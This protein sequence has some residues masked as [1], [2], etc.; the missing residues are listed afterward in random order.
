LRGLLVVTGP[1]SSQ[2][3]VRGFY[4][5]SVVSMT[6]WV[7]VRTIT[8]PDGTGWWH[9]YGGGMEGEETGDECVF[10]TRTGDHSLTTELSTRV[11]CSPASRLAVRAHKKKH[12]PGDG[13]APAA[14]RRLCLGRSAVDMAR[15]RDKS[16]FVAGLVLPAIE[17]GPG[18]RL[19]RCYL[20][21]VRRQELTGTP[22]STSGVVVSTSAPS[23]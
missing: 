15:A 7:F 2:G 19:R 16:E 23:V 3:S 22:V 20:D 10:L 12:I 4:P 5:E 6:V 13:K 14:M 8:D 21:F 18:S 11:P 17:E 9:Y 1:V